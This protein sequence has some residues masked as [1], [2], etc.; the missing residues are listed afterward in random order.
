M[1]TPLHDCDN[2]NPAVQKGKCNWVFDVALRGNLQSGWV[3]QACNCEQGQKC[4]EPTTKGVSDGE[5][6][7]TDCTTP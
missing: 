7:T 5:K 6:A 4:P 2:P 3:L 1:G